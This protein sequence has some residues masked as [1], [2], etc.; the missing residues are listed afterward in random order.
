MKRE[1]V[2][3]IKLSNSNC[4]VNVYLGGQIGMNK[5]ELQEYLK[6]DLAEERILLKAT[7]E[8]IGK[9]EKA[10]EISESI[11]FTATGNTLY[12]ERT[13]IYRYKADNVVNIS[14]VFWD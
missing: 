7:L 8:R 4:N 6:A 14:G 3:T 1:S 5:K 12:P 10:L 9:I 13:S 11:E 2:G